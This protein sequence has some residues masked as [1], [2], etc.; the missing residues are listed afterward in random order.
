MAQALSPDL[1]V[2]CR[3]LVSMASSAPD[4]KR[5]YARIQKN[6]FIWSNL[7]HYGP[8]QW[9]TI[10]ATLTP[11]DGFDGTTWAFL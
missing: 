8:P 5:H 2:L 11:V 9:F 10:R 1:N 6:T 7:L 3:A 4:I